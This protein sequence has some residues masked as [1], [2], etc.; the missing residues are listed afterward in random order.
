[1]VP[2]RIGLQ[3]LQILIWKAD[4]K[5][6]LSQAARNFTATFLCHSF[7]RCWKG[8]KMWSLSLGDGW[9][10]Q[11][12]LG[13]MENPSVVDVIFLLKT[14]YYICILYFLHTS[15]S[16]YIYVYVYIYTYI[17]VYDFTIF[18]LLLATHIIIYISIWKLEVQR[19]FLCL[20]PSIR[21]DPRTSPKIPHV[22][23]GVFSWSDCSDH[24]WKILS[25]MS[26]EVSKRLVS[27]L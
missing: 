9:H 4:S 24:N 2:K 21:C 18:Y 23:P 11:Y 3:S 15:I 8:W 6:G 25:R 27:G 20:C 14:G 16:I 17:Y 22:R 1:M 10:P 26:Q 13:K 19:S 7:S 5:T 12:N